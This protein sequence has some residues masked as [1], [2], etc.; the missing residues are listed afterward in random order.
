MDRRQ[1]Y[2]Y[3]ETWMSIY[4]RDVEVTIVDDDGS[5]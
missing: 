4:A 2:A 1:L 3:L 5:T